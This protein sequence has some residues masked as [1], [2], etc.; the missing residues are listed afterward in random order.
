[1]KIVVMAPANRV[2]GDSSRRSARPDDE[3]HRLDGCRAVQ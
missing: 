2:P 1:V 3:G